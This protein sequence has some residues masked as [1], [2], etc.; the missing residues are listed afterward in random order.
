MIFTSDPVKFSYVR[1]VNE[2]EHPMAEFAFEAPLGLRP[3]KEWRKTIF[4]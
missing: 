3:P 1:E 4:I 2:G